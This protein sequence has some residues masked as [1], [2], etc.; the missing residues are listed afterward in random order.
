MASFVELKA[1]KVL[2]NG[3]GQVED[4]QELGDSGTA[5]FEVDGQFSHPSASGRQ[6]G[7][8]V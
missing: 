2:D 7:W 8:G 5:H 6:T 1:D 4:V 3:G